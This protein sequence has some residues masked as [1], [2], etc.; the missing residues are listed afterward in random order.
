M[1]DVQRKPVDLNNANL[2][3]GEGAD[4]NHIQL[5]IQSLSTNNSI[6]EFL[7]RVVDLIQHKCGCNL[8]GIRVLDDNGCI[9]YHSYIGYSREFW[10]EENMIQVSHEDCGCSR[11]VS[12]KLLPSDKKA[13]T[14]AGSLCI[15][16]SLA[17]ASSLSKEEAS[18]YRGVCVTHGYLSLAIIPI[19]HGGEK[20]G[21]IQMNDQR[22]G[23]C[24]PT[25]MEFAESI[26]PLVGEVLSRDKAERRLKVSQEQKMMLENIVGNI[27]SLAYVVNLDNCELI[28]VNNALKQVIGSDTFGR[29]CYEV[30]GE[31]NVCQNCPTVRIPDYNSIP[32]AWE[33]Y[34]IQHDCYFLAEKKQINWPNGSIIDTLFVTDITK[35]RKAE[36]ALVNSNVELQQINAVLEE[37]IMERQQ[38]QEALHLLN[39]ELESKI[40]E[41]TRNLQE[42]NAALEEE[43]QERLTVEEYNRAQAELLDLSYDF[44]LVRDLD[45]KVIYWNRGAE[46]GYGFS[47]DEALGQVTHS[48]LH[49][50]FPGTLEQITNTIES[51]GHWEGELLHTRKD[52]EKIIVKSHQVLRR[53]AAGEPEAILEINRDI[54]ARKQ[55][56]AELHEL[57]EELEKR[58]EERTA[59]L[60]EFN[61]TLEEEIIERQSVQEALLE[62]QNIL[63]RSQAHYRGLIQNMQ[64]GFTYSKVIC[65]S[66]HR[67][68]DLEYVEVN[69]AF[70]KYT[71]LKAVDIIGRLVSEASPNFLQD[72]AGW[73]KLLGNVALTRKAINTEV[74]LQKYNS[75]FRVA[76]YSPEIGHVAAICEDITDS[77]KAEEAL[78]ESQE[79]YETVMAQSTEAIA[80]IDFGTKNVIEVNGTF[81]R[82]FG[83][84]P[85]DLVGKPVSDFGLLPL[86]N[87]DS[88]DSLADDTSWS[89]PIQLYRRK[90]GENVY[91][92]LA[93]AMMRHRGRQ[94][95]ILSYRDVT[96]QQKLQLE[97]QRQVQ[98]ASTV[99]KSQLPPEYQDDRLTIRTI[100]E[101]A[102][103]VSGDF[104]GYRW[105]HG[106]SILHGYLIDA[107]GHGIATALHTSAISSLLSE[108]MDRKEAW[109]EETLGW[110]NRSLNKYLPHDSFVAM[111]AF[112][113]DLNRRRLTCTSC[114]INSMLVSSK[115]LTGLMSIRGLYLGVSD[116]PQFE[117]KTFTV[118]DGD[119]FYFMTDGIYDILPQAATKNV[120]DFMATVELLRNVAIHG[121]IEDDCSAVCLKIGA[122]ERLPLTL[123]FSGLDK[124]SDLQDRFDKTLS[125]L[126]GQE[127]AKLGM[128]LGE[129]MT[130]AGKYGTKIRVKINKIGS[131][132]L[133]RVQDDGPGFDGNSKVKEYQAFGLENIFEKILDQQSGRGIPIMMAWTDR[134][135]YNGKGNEVML[136]K[137]V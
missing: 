6:Q 129:A 101:P 64:N 71:G 84:H 31:M 55:A 21:L 133:I 5:L 59:Q 37:E 29:R 45:S 26:A 90:D 42:I 13:L 15:N 137:K 115:S 123:S 66:D 67:P 95:V 20:L 99:Q 30:F 112:T 100:F 124:L 23:Q 108:I 132:L 34:D 74:F 109:T 27:G 10:E 24:S 102:T 3:R 1:D 43:M 91:A 135:L 65:G 98:L 77:K 72:H 125:N 52:G 89:A 113:L 32:N 118:Q 93:A 41:R 103:L 50:I 68:V 122:G 62:H 83:Y 51:E 94:L 33:H 25:A 111:L 128:V 78:R 136:V 116:L 105:F 53:N 58:V 127:A 4:S 130:N 11:I 106:G 2:V 87:T 81:S 75:Y 22:A 8:V 96:E 9:P 17:F 82:I 126:A 131:N 73:T 46:L 70:E 49:T 60:Q 110:L 119:T 114:G 86:E 36:Q 92:E 47:A 80:V 56:E 48:L 76:A 14:A 61:A 7:D 79:W 19:V 35:Q 134:V 104:Y 38:A 85:E 107:T 120:S 28:Y 39:A 12:G 121:S 57:N 54:T 117:T 88:F 40:A 97:L 18:A 63:A 69:E 44:I 16:D